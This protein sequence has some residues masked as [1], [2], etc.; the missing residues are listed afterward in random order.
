MKSRRILTQL[1]FGF[2]VLS[3]LPLALFVWWSSSGIERTLQQSA[4]V[5]LSSLADKKTDQINT[6]LDE[7]IRESQSLAKSPTTQHALSILP[8]Q[9]ASADEVQYAVDEARYRDYYENAVVRGGDHDLLLTDH[10]GTVVFSMRHQADFATNLNTGRYRDSKLALAHRQA[11]AL[12]ETQ[13]TAAA[14]YAPSANR[15]A[16]F[17]VSPVIRDGKL[18]GTIALQLSL[19]HLMR[20]ATD[21]TGLGRTGETIITQLEGGQALYVTPLRSA[22]DAAFRLRRPISALG[23]PM[24]AAIRGER[25]SGVSTDYAGTPVIAAWRYLPA[26]R[27]FMVVKTNVDEAFAPARQLRRQSLIALAALSL[28]AFAA[29]LAIARSIVRPIRNLNE[30]TRRI[31][32]GELAERAPIG[33]SREFRLL[34]KSFNRMA[35]RLAQEQGQLERRVAERT[36]ALALSNARFDDLVRRISVGVYVFRYLPDGGMRFDYVSPRFCEL[37]GVAEADAL[38]DARLPFSLIH[39]DDLP[40][41]MRVNTL[42]AQTLAPFRV[43]CRFVLGGET[44]WYYVE[45]DGVAVPEGGSVWNGVVTDITERK[46]GEQA[47][48]HAA[49]EQLA[50]FES[51]TIGIGLLRNRVVI[52]CNRRLEEMLGYQP[53]EMI[54]QTTRAWYLDE[55]S[56][57]A[58]GEVY[59]ELAAGGIHRRDQELLSKHGTRF[60]AK[61]AG[62]AIDPSDL[63]RGTVWMFDDV[64]QERQIAA[65]ME[66]A[67]HAAEAANRA[68][69][70]FLANMSHEIRTPMNAVL[71]LTQLA[72]DGERSREQR[73]YLETVLASG[74]ALLAVLNDILDY[75]KVEAGR[76]EVE[77]VPMNLEEVLRGVA[78]LFAAQLEEKSLEFFL[79]VAADL[80]A[81]LQGDPLRLAQVLNNLVGN[82]IKFTERGEI[83]LRVSLGA[84]DGDALRLRFELRDTGIGLSAA[85][86]E[87]IFQA[88]SQAD[89]SITRKHGG[90]GLGLAICQKLVALMGG[91]IGV[92]STEGEGSTFW[93]TLAA[94]ALESPA[95]GAGLQ[96]LGGRKVLVA[97]NAARARAIL[98]Q[99]L[100]HWGLQVEPVADGDAALAGLQAAAAAGAPFHTLLLDW[101]MPGSSGLA[102]ARRIKADAEQGHF[103]YPHVVM[104]VGQ[105]DR[106]ALDALAGELRLGGIVAKPVTASPLLDA[107]LHSTPVAGPPRLGN[108]DVAARYEGARVLLVEDNAQNRQVAAGLLARRGIAVRT[109]NDGA[110]A[111][112]ISAEQ[113]F[114]LI[115]M[116]LHMPVMDGLEA[117][118]VIRDRAG[119]AAL[120]IVAMTAAV[121]P[122]DRERCR[123]AGMVDFV[124]KP[125]EPEVLDAVLARWLGPLRV[126]NGRAAPAPRMDAQSLEGFDFAAALR[127]MDGDAAMLGHLLRGFAD[128]NQDAAMQIDA[129]VADGYAESAIS[130]LHAI[131]GAAANLG[132][133][134]LA[135]AAQAFE[136]ALRAGAEGSLLQARAELF[137]EVLAHALGIVRAQFATA[138]AT[139]APQADAAALAAALSALRPYL[140]RRELVP[141]A[142]Q[143]TLRRL[144]E[145]DPAAGLMRRLLRQID[146][147]DHDGALAILAQIAATQNL[148]LQA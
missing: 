112:A 111:V 116:D 146:H 6:Y 49:D 83:A 39:P 89:G 136:R 53:G 135:D 69:S 78:D 77:A 70:E 98:A 101:R 63:S 46:R 51:A 88:F 38:R 52:K 4:L 57:L 99:L 92:Q 93:F 33:G 47:L 123:A 129:M 68:K 73:D 119:A 104:M 130:R 14:P 42:A 97:A 139:P 96:Q 22:P 114:D 105:S 71:G 124:P 23:R 102:I 95:P 30:A 141:D 31:A 67:R 45:S 110:E 35:D 9:M 106:T 32:E 82:A 12:L 86:T 125:V 15:P 60:I 54:G 17:V 145:Y 90:T 59:G 64:T 72:L 120:P 2:L 113:G 34:G 25:G 91:E 107:L 24:E 61:I 87:R 134:A 81:R 18:L 27:W 48:R 126:A 128:D 3:P 94:R 11:M 29:A 84:R 36:H 56:Y 103:P 109:A 21:A 148:E 65:E 100:G 41:V 117:S 142:L 58:G 19:E 137:A 28:V 8:S 80:P 66:R 40:E 131:K 7:R 16:V 75:S 79:D 121:M 43:E 138:P 13:V 132:V 26:L 118:R 20:V 140:E 50:I 1:L 62:R 122:E 143:E 55:R 85:Q 10:A 147:F 133:V 74:R 44:R 5:S 127:R 144:A 37:T 76:L 108:G 115:L